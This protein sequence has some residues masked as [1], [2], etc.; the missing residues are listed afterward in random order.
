MPPNALIKRK[1]LFLLT[2]LGLTGFVT[3][4]GAYIVAANLPAYSRETGTGLIIIGLL[5]AL[6]D[7]VEI[8]VK[9]LGGLLSGRW[10]EWRVLRLGLV[11]FAL[12][13]GSYFYSW[14][15]MADSCPPNAG[16]RRCLVF[17]NVRDAPR[18]LLF[19]QKRDGPF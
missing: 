19:G 8:L 6:Y 4:F 14:L 15:P 13:S 5:I 17:G 1:E 11:V 16:G 3:S 9:P 18:P 10:G 7:I 12:A 2:V